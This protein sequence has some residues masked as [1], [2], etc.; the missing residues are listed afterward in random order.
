[1]RRS[2]RRVANSLR[3]VPNRHAFITDFATVNNAMSRERLL[4]HSWSE[5]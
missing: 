3:N 5:F 1:M 2:L 4:E